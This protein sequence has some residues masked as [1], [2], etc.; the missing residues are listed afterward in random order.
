MPSNSTVP[1]GT[2]FDAK[3]QQEISTAKDPSQT[4]FSLLEQ[5]PLFRGNSLLK[6]AE[7][8]G[9]IEDVVK[10]ARGSKA[11]LHLVFDDI[12][13]KNGNTHLLMPL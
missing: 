9:H 7:V 13:L 2:T 3:L 4:R 10:A 12:V 1:A 11:S 5:H 6:G 8:E